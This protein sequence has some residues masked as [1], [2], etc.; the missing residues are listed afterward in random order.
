MSSTTQVIDTY[1]EAY[2]EPDATRRRTL[3]EQA[4]AADGVL[5]DPP[6]DAAGHDG[7]DEMFA[8]VQSTFAGHT[9]RRTSAV[10]EH[11]GVARY[12]WELRAPDG[13]TALSGMDV[14]SFDRTGRL[15]RVTGWFGELPALDT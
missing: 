7:I 4:W 8:A 10:D 3:I 9:F 5:A 13:T 1:L 6:M 11:H 15:A 14:A 2:G 12:G